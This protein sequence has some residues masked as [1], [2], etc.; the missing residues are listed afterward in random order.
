[1]IAL[2]AGWITAGWADEHVK[3][4][5]NLTAKTI[6]IADFNEIRVDGVIDV[7]YEQS[8]DPSSIEV[9]VDQNLHP[10]V[11]IEVKDRTLSVGFRGAKVD[12]YTKFIIKTHSKWL[13]AAK[14]S[15]NANLVVTGPLSGDETSI[16]ANANSLVQ[17]KGMV[18]VSKLDL[19]ATGSANFV[20][21]RL[22]VGTLDC[23]ITG[24]GSI[25]LKS[26]SAKE[27]E[28]KIDGSGDIHAFG[29]A[30]PKLTCKVTGSGLAEVHATD[31]L[32]ATLIGKGNIRYKGPTAVQERLIGKGKIEEVK[33]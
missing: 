9:T 25:T 12:H 24:S 13:A 7:Y 17:L 3:G 5:G 1:M 10:Y 21:D 30:V 27:G 31:D 18:R 26:G 2:L 29:V 19:T 15:G 8:D 6:S 28:Y 14:I 22:E 23:G 33:E 16:R 20:I 32:K 11:D 4:N